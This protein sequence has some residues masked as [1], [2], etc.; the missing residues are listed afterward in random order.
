MMTVA[1]VLF[2]A[3]LALALEATAN[4]RRHGVYAQDMGDVQ[5]DSTS[6]GE[7]MGD[8]LDPTL[9]LEGDANIGVRGI[10][11]SGTGDADLGR[12]ENLRVQTLMALKELGVVIG[13]AFMVASIFLLMVYT[14]KL[15]DTLIARYHRRFGEVPEDDVE[16]PAALVGTFKRYKN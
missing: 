2:R 9:I 3:L 6:H 5:D 4:R 16:D 10:G 15:V 13:V 8:F 11:L 12:V 14:E 7:D 1:H